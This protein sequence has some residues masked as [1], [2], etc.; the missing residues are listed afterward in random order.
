MFFLFLLLNMA[1]L[2]PLVNTTHIWYTGV[3][4]GKIPIKFL[5]DLLCAQIEVRLA[6]SCLCLLNADTPGACHQASLRLLCLDGC[7]RHLNSEKM[8]CFWKMQESEWKNPCQAGI[9]HQL[10]P[11]HIPKGSSRIKLANFNTT[12]KSRKLWFLFKVL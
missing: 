11:N 7:G 2:E 3:H 8:P 5:W 6:F 12:W 4:A 10:L 1:S 9:I